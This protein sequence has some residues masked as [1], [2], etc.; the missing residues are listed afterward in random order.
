[1]HVEH[2]Q[3]S[4]SRVNQSPVDALLSEV[5]DMALD[6]FGREESEIVRRHYTATF[7]SPS[8]Y[9]V[10]LNNARTQK[11]LVDDLEKNLWRIRVL[12]QQIEAAKYAADLTI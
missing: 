6:S 10:H 11:L 12:N 2:R 7:A 3:V 1:M 9:L 8:H 5:N 4:R